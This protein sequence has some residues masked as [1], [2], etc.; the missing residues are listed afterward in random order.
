MKLSKRLMRV[1]LIA[2]VLLAVLSACGAKEAMQQSQ[3]GEASNLSGETMNKG[4][5]APSFT[6]NDLSGKP[7]RLADMKGQKVYVK[8]WASWCSICLAGLEDLDSL[9]AQ[10]NGF[11]VLTIVTPNYK[12]EKSAKDFTAWFTKQPYS[13][14]TVLLDDGGTW[15]KKFGLRGYPSSYY[16]GTDGIL[17][18]SSPGHAFNDVIEETFKTIK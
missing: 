5:A 3:A 9:A 14:L 17:V 8:Y 13:H 7:I 16:I 10:D 6:L 1:A 4:E 15:A 12:G 2:G 18:K 11:Q